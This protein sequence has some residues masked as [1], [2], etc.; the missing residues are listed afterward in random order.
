MHNILRPG[1]L[2]SAFALG[3][4]AACGVAPAAASTIS[5]VWTGT[6]TSVDPISTATVA[7]GQKIGITLSLDDTVPDQDP[8]PNR[9]IYD[10]QPPTPHLV[11]SVNIGGVTDI[12]SFQ[13]GTVR[14]NDGGI[15]EF[16]INTGDQLIGDRFTIDFKN[17]TPG[18][19]TS[20]ALPLSI[21]PKDFAI[22]TFLVNGPSF[23][24]PSFFPVFSGTIDFAGLN[25]TQTPLPASGML[26]VSALAGLLGFGAWRRR[27]STA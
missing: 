20:D 18:V 21:D 12:G 23:N 9:G 17:P 4:V 19:L 2:A 26:F 14:A 5:Y 3:I 6:V 16:M 7:V 27:S 15:D 22:A 8:S 10:Q 11:V 25:L 1:L 13:F 24:L